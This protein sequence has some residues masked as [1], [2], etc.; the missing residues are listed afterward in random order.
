MRNVEAVFES[1]TDARVARERLISQGVP[2][3][4][5]SLLDRSRPHRN[6][7][8][9]ETSKGRGLWANLK[10]MVSIPDQDK[11]SYQDKLR[12]GGFLLTASVP[13]DKLERA[14]AVLEFKGVT[15]FISNSNPPTRLNLGYPGDAAGEGG[16]KGRR[17]LFQSY[18][19]DSSSGESAEADQH[20][21]PT[22]AAGQFQ[23]RVIELLETSETVSFDKQL[24]IKEEVVVRKVARE[25]LDTVTSTVR[26][27]EAGI[28][29]QSASHNPD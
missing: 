16:S 23:E 7:N 29:Q 14:L 15:R 20:E 13:D 8:H 3:Q 11:P 10:D 19:G 22:P 2:P 12:S 27:T 18:S 24:R 26:R 25:H 17:L 5:V 4:R 6:P 1:E 9:E 21:A 28:R